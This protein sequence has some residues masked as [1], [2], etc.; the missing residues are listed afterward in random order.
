VLLERST[1]Q[2]KA[3]VRL[4]QPAAGS[5]IPEVGLVNGRRQSD[6]VARGHAI[7]FH[8]AESAD[9]INPTD[10]LHQTFSEADNSS[11]SQGISRMSITMFTKA[12][13]FSPSRAT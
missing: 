1:L 3:T 4:L 2:F 6:A 8:L 7:E 12:C 9:Q 5:T 13:H 11:S 10:E